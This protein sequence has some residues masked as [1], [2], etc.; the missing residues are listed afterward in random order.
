[1]LSL[2]L[3]AQSSLV[4]YLSTSNSVYDVSQ[5]RQRKRERLFERRAP[6]TPLRTPSMVDSAK[7]MGFNKVENM[8]PEYPLEKPAPLWMIMLAQSTKGY[9][10]WVKDILKE[11]GLYEIGDISIQ[12]N[13][14]QMNEMLW[15]VKSLT[16]IQ[17]ITFPDG[18]PTEEDVGFTN[19]NSDGVFKITKQLKT[20]TEDDIPVPA[21]EDYKIVDGYRMCHNCQRE[22]CINLGMC[23]KLYYQ[24]KSNNLE[25]VASRLYNFVENPQKKQQ[26]KETS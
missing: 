8:Y 22:L 2:R 9:P 3:R 12:I 19:L 18:L 17:P 25:K 21:P 6:K 23:Q 5:M 1:M 16:K 14:P 26:Q 13:A 15:Q 11:L 24:A 7:K 10:Y 4:R 20:L